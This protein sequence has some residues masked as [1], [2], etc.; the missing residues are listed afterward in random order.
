MTFLGLCGPVKITAPS[1]VVP[2]GFLREECYFAL[3]DFI[4]EDCQK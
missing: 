4:L 2:F 3:V 1:L